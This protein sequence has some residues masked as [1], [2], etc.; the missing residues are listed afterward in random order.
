M[1]LR[2]LNQVVSRTFIVLMTLNLGGCLSRNVTHE[3]AIDRPED[4]ARYA[5]IASDLLK[6]QDFFKYYVFTRPERLVVTNAVFGKKAGAFGT[7]VSEKYAIYCAV[8]YFVDPANDTRLGKGQASFSLEF[9]TEIANPGNFR[10]I[11]KQN[12]RNPADTCGTWST[13]RLDK[14]IGHTFTR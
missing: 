1:M 13:M 6:K 5:A 7:T 8:V 4:Q 12:L 3:A 10:A 11:V 9:E 14:L 2:N